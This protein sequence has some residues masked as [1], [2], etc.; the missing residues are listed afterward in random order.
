[1]SHTD[2]VVA[3]GIATTYGAQAGA[4]AGTAVAKAALLGTA[5]T[6]AAPVVGAG[7]AVAGTY[8]VLKDLFKGR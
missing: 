8:V 1:M 3:A 5:A 6:A 7:L 2:E 4:A